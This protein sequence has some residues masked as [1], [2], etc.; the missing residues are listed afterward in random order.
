MQNTKDNSAPCKIVRPPLLSLVV[1]LFLAACSPQIQKGQKEIHRAHPKIIAHR[2]GKQEW[3][4]NTLCAF[5][6]NVKRGVDAIELDVQVTKDGIVVVY[7]PEDL[8]Q[9]TTESGPIAEK[10]A[11]EVTNLDASEKYAGPRTFKTV[12]SPETLRVP[13]LNAVLDGIPN[14]PIVVDLKSL[15]AEPL[16]DAIVRT[17]PQ[18]HWPRLRFYS[19]STEHTKQI[20]SKKPDAVIFED[21][22]Q[23]FQ[24]LMAFSTTRRCLIQSSQAWVGYELMRELKVCD[25]TQ[26]SSA[27]VDKLPF[28]LWSPESL[29]CTKMM[30]GATI[31]FFG[32]NNAESYEKAR[33][34]GA[35]AVFTD[36]PGVL[37]TK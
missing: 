23:T 37:K 32:I 35:D 4:E 26:L 20:R 30:T 19:T 25:K 7:H 11:T 18:Q 14:L 9:W 3:P 28:I 17:V 13:T 6:Q 33:R 12:C 29:Q 36:I 15:P 24:R 1:L 27:C 34:F 16:V 21:R 5:Q 10:T 31:V 8:S 2:G 22:S